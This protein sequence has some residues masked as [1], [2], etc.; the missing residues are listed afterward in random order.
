[1]DSTR[2]PGPEQKT[3]S[4]D[5]RLQPTPD[6]GSLGPSSDIHSGKPLHPQLGRLRS[7]V[8]ITVGILCALPFVAQG[9]VRAAWDQ[10]SEYLTLQGKPQAASPAIMSQHEIERLDRQ[11]AQKQ[12][13]LLLERAINHYDGAN[14]QIAARVDTWRRGH[15]K[16]TPHLTSLI[17]AGLNSNDLRVRAAA[18]EIDL[19]AMNLAKVPSNVD[20]FAKE[21]QSRDQSVRNWALWTLGLLGNRGV[22]TH[23]V[24][25]ILITHLYDSEAESRH[26]AVEGL[27]LLGT[28]ETIAPLLRVFHDDP[29]AM[30]RE[31]AACSLAQSGMLNQ[32]QRRSA[33]PQLLDFADD[34]V[35]DPQTHSWVF[36][37]LRDITG[38]NL[39]DETSAWRNWYSTAGGL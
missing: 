6:F 24:T 35:L 9:T 32:Q 16:L 23:R 14:D 26:W 33:I 4:A 3:A 27:A 22:D 7:I 30:V 13:E 8:A 29:S 31:R 25:N 1:M 34:P 21:A 28:D 2:Q 10:F 19:A 11:S 5:P 38:Q 36:H 20:V 12:A 37:A 17:T 39:P 18:I 15:L